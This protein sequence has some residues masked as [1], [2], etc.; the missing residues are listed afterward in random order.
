MPRVVPSEIVA[1]I[2]LRPKSYSIPTSQLFRG[3]PEVQSSTG[4]LLPRKSR[5]TCWPQELA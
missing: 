1:F 3:C 5:G 2:D 4:S